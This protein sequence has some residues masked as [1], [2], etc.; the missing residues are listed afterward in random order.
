MDM[1]VKSSIIKITHKLFGTLLS[2]W[3]KFWSLTYNKFNY[4]F[5]DENLKNC[6]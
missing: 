6:D 4:F 3:P 5:S 1:V 2:Y